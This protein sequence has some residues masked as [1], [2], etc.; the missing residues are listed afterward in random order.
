MAKKVASS[1]AEK[2]EAKKLFGQLH[3]ALKAIGKDHSKEDATAVVESHGRYAGRLI[4]DGLADLERIKSF[5]PLIEGFASARAIFFEESTVDAM[6][7][8]SSCFLSAVDEGVKKRKAIKRVKE[9]VDFYTLSSKYSDRIWKKTDH[10]PKLSHIEAAH[11]VLEEMKLSCIDLGMKKQFYEYDEE[12][13][14]WQKITTLTVQK[15]AVGIIGDTAT[16]STAGAVVSLVATLCEVHQESFNSATHMINLANVAFDLDTCQAVEHNAEHMFTYCLPYEYDEHARTPYTD[17]ILMQYACGDQAWIDC[18]WEMAGFCLQS[19]YFMNKMFWLVGDGANGKSTV[20]RLLHELVGHD[21]TKTGFQVRDL[22]KDFFLTS[23]RGRR[24]ALCG[25]A[26][27][28]M[29]NIDLLKQFTGGDHLSTNVKFGDYVQFSN[30]AKLILCMNRAPLVSSHEALKPLVRRIV[31]LP[32]EYRITQPDPSVEKRMLAELPGHF[33]K[34]VEGLKRL[35][36]QGRFTPVPR[37][38]KALSIWAGTANLLE[39]YLSENIIEDES[40]KT[41]LKELWDDYQ[42]WMNAWGGRLWESDPYNIRNVHQLSR[43]IMARFRCRKE[44]EYCTYWDNDAKTTVRGKQVFLYGLN[45]R[46]KVEKEDN[47]I[48]GAN[49]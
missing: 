29:E 41:R 13:G 28:R 23:V 10:G 30:E 18:F 14:R 19:P 33:N 4:A 34:A 9:Q 26:A 22:S 43:E 49:F 12:S 47:T 48:I 25:D 8:F 15:M 38:E 7:H 11:C 36:K 5:L 1:S 21:L 37:G 20:Q 40:S 3:Q 32:F 44:T 46:S 2:D 16:S 24:M 17:D 35:R 42:S 31:W 27:V 45:L 6:A 39:V